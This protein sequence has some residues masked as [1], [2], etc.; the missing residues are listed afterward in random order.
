[1]A[2]DRFLRPVCLQDFPEE[3]LPEAVREAN[4]WKLPQ[5]IC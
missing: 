2:I 3:L 5:R 1:M 4:P